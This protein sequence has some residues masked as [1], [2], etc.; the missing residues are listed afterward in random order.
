MAASLADTA[1]STFQPEN[2]TVHRER[3]AAARS[4]QCALFQPIDVEQ[5]LGKEP[6]TF[7]FY[8]S[9]KVTQRSD[10]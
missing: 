1:G 9:V 2:C 8:E 6:H 7:D 5:A 4:R 3:S 10:H